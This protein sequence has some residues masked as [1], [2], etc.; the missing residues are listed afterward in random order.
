MIGIEKSL[1]RFPSQSLIYFID[2]VKGE[3]RTIYHIKRNLKENRTYLR[4]KI[5]INIHCDL[6]T[7]L[8]F[9]YFLFFINAKENEQ[10]LI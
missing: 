10:H 5:F 4:K 8:F 7:K 6:V 1:L 9:L 2:I 3:I